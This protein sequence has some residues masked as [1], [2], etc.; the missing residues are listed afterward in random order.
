MILLTI[1]AQLIFI[2][3][4]LQSIINHHLTTISN[5][6]DEHRLNSFRESAASEAAK[7]QRRDVTVGQARHN[8][9]SQI[10]LN[11][12]RSMTLRAERSNSTARSAV[13]L[14]ASLQ[15]S[16]A[17]QAYDDFFSRPPRR[18]GRKD[19]VIGFASYLDSFNVAVLCRSLRV[20]NKD[21][22]VIL[23][24][25]A[26][27]SEFVAIFQE[28]G[29]VSMLLDR[30]ELEPE[31]LRKYHPST[32][33]WAVFGLLFSYTF[34]EE[35]N[36][37][38]TSAFKD[39][40]KRVLCVDARDT[41]FQGD[42]FARLPS[43]VREPRSPHAQKDMH[44]LYTFGEQVKIA[45]RDCG[46]NSRW[47]LQCFGQS[48]LDALGHD[49]VICSGVLVGSTKRVMSYFDTM[50]S[51]LTGQSQHG[52]FSRCESNGV[53]QG[54]HNYVVYKRLV[55]ELEVKFEETA[56]EAL[57]AHIQTSL[58]TPQLASDGSHEMRWNSSFRGFEVVHQYDRHE[59]LMRSLQAAFI[60]SLDLRNVTTVFGLSEGCANF[61]LYEDTDI[62]RGSCDKGSFRAMS[63]RDCCNVCNG[64]DG[65]RAFAFS[66][67]VCYFK[68]CPDDSQYDATLK[69]YNFYL[70]LRTG[71]Y[72]VIPYEPTLTLTLTLTLRRFPTS[73]PCST[74]RRSS[75]QISCGSRNT[76]PTIIASSE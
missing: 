30:K 31:F 7:P 68:V 74:Q 11:F 20:Y 73:L 22:H 18:Q 58:Y 47:L 39:Y 70:K 32:L 37:G 17:S 51:I 12:R 26:L 40:Y 33:R 5:Q 59:N 36:L 10:T 50:S 55:P 4:L 16:T 34:D 61:T 19:V 56:P 49:F 1:I 72:K 41:A 28:T 44:F 48:A 71:K 9:F 43:Y 24:L 25:E 69:L 57:V 62:F 64:M 2:V 46:W 38:H 3:L 14:S 27:D 53:D 29:S 15:I 6:D 67:S 76:L 75:T 13:A 21:A 23:I 54:A 35:N 60:P 63:I 52:L 42:P 45:I 8:S 66:R 65:C